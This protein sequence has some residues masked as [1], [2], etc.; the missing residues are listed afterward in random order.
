MPER[1]EIEPLFSALCRARGLR[2]PHDMN[3]FWAAMFA[4]VGP[5][6]K[7][8]RESLGDWGEGLSGFV[9]LG[10]LVVG[11]LGLFARPWMLG[12]APWGMAMPFVWGAGYALIDWRRQAAIARVTIVDTDHEVGNVDAVREQISRTYDWIALLWGLACAIAGIAAFVMSWTPP[13]APEWQPPA[14][15]VSVD[16]SP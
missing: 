12:I 14:G 7:R 13:P 10:G 8:M 2:Y 15:A 5:R 9:L 11:S 6:R 4:E 1:G 3:G 16:I